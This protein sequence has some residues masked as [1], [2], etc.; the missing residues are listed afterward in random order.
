MASCSCNSS[1]TAELLRLLILTFLQG[2]VTHS[3][4][5]GSPYRRAYKF[6]GRMIKYSSIIRLGLGCSPGLS[7]IVRGLRASLHARTWPPL[8]KLLGPLAIECIEPNVVFTLSR[9]LCLISGWHP[10]IIP[11]QYVHTQQELEFSASFSLVRQWVEL[12]VSLHIWM[13]NLIAQ[14]SSAESIVSCDQP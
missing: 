12:T 6:A 10:L 8:A 9:L 5:A 1:G 2:L 13:S 3:T 11:M 4:I 14:N 7:S